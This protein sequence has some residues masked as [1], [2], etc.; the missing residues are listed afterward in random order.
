MSNQQFVHRFIP[1]SAPETKERMLKYIGVSDAEE[2]FSEIP[3]E[4]RFNGTLNIPQEPVSE[5]EVERHV[6]NMLRKNITT[7]DY[8]SFLGAGCYNHYVPAICDVINSRPEFLTAY[9]GNEYVDLGRQQALFE[10]ASMLGEMLDMD[11]VGAP[12][13]DGVSAAGDAMI[14]AYRCTERKRILVPELIGRERME[15]LRSYCSM[16]ELETVACDPLSGLINLT[17]LKTRLSDNVACVYVDNPNYLGG[18]ETK[19]QEIS[20]LAHEAGALFVV[21]VDPI[22]LGVIKPPGQYGADIVVLDAQALG[23]HQ[24][25]GGAQVGY[26]ACRDRGELI[27]VMPCWLYSV[28]RTVVEGELAYSWHALYDRMF[29]VIREE[30]QNFTGTSAGLWAITAGVYLSLMGSHGLEQLCYSIL[31]NTHYAMQSLATIPGVNVNRLN[32]A[33][34]KEFL[35]DFNKTGKS[36]AEINRQ[37]LD[38]EIFGGKD[39]SGEFP[40]YGE[41]ALYCVTEVHTKG[42]IDKLI[43]SL[44]EVLA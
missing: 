44:K 36:V 31:Y 16:M 28:T 40:Q 5:F 4:I 26:I 12:V 14:M 39:I 18:I 17:D 7:E 34:F 3:K 6:N 10:T 19:V 41:S 42:Q 2:L 33:P 32:A 38:Y 1:N 43:S 30:A 27:N 8:V 35:V 9:S 24:N 29:Y 21:G 15:T 11:V 13:Y 20:N 22:S 37:L 25:Y 23:M